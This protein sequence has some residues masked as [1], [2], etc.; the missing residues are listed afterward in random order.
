MDSLCAS[1]PWSGSW[2]WRPLKAEL[3]EAEYGLH[4]EKEGHR[5]GGGRPGSLPASKKG[6]SPVRGLAPSLVCAY[7]RVSHAYGVVQA[8]GDVVGVAGDVDQVGPSRGE[9]PRS[10]EIISLSG[11]SSSK[12]TSSGSESMSLFGSSTTRV[13]STPGR[14]LDTLCPPRG[15][16]LLRFATGKVHRYS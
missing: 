16:Y 11:V 1:R 8:Y 7:R 5:D 10:G 6:A 14:L 12:L 4:G 15:L 2:P 3:L 13:W 9:S